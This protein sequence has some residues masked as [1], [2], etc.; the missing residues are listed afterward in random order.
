[1]IYSSSH[2]HGSGKWPCWRLNW[3]SRAPCWIHFPLPWWEGSE[4]YPKKLH[5][6]RAVLRAT[7]PQVYRKPRRW[8]EYDD[9]NRMSILVFFF[10]FHVHFHFP[11]NFQTKPTYQVMTLSTIPDSRIGRS[12]LIPKH[13]GGPL[14][15]IRKLH[16]YFHTDLP[17]YCHSYR[18]SKKS[19]DFSGSCKGW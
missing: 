3:S 14:I 12:I 9:V 7:N 2:N 15:L 13:Q 1:M 4:Y 11:M 19:M 17:S 10:R 18:Y 6:K 16:W 5:K 8:M